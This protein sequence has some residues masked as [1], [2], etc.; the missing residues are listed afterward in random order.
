MGPYVEFLYQCKI[1]HC[2]ISLCPFSSDEQIDDACE[3]S[4]RSRVKS[5]HARREAVLRVKHLL[6]CEKELKSDNVEKRLKALKNLQL[7]TEVLVRL[8]CFKV[9]KTWFWFE[10]YT[11]MFVIL[12]VIL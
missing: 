8:S 5:K 12:F 7:E 11:T 2:I 6:S 10:K 1:K 3:S 9:K 4:K